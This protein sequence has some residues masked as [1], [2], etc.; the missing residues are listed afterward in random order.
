ME[1]AALIISLSKQAIQVMCVAPL[2]STKHV[3]QLWE[4]VV[5]PINQTAHLTTI[6]PT[7]KHPPTSLQVECDMDKSQNGPYT[8]GIIAAVLADAYTRTRL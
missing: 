5:L 7:F 2:A 6:T 4:W 8:Y 1:Y 3:V